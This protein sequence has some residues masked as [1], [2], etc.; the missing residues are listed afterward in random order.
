MMG[1]NITPF[2]IHCTRAYTGAQRHKK[3]FGSLG[4]C[5]RL[6]LVT[7]VGRDFIVGVGV[8]FHVPR[9]NPE[10]SLFFIMHGA[11]IL[12][13]MGQGSGIGDRNRHANFV[14]LGAG[15]T[16]ENL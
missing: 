7:G 13:D 8:D 6:L 10:I 14:G 16:R 3:V 9:G 15:A 2:V 12:G 11:Q 1:Q 5:H 4:F